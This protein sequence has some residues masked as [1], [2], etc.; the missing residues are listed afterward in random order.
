MNDVNNDIVNF[1]WMTQ[2]ENWEEMK[3]IQISPESEIQ[4]CLVIQTDDDWMID[5]LITFWLR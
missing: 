1:E 3:V 5:W 4:D 2:I